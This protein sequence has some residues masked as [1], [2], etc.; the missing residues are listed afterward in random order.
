MTML[1]TVICSF[2][3]I[4]MVMPNGMF[5]KSR[6]NNSKM[7]MKTQKIWITK[8]FLRKKNKVGGITHLHFKLYYEASV[9]K[10]SMVQAQ[11]QTHGSMEQN[12]EPGNEPT[13]I[14]STNLWQWGKNIQKE[15]DSFLKKWCWGNR[16][17]TC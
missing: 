1:P 9:L 15:K 5:H 10:N 7:C 13:I 4:P 17:D 2:S 16:T 14:W 6:L 3:T 12:R 11:K 8:T